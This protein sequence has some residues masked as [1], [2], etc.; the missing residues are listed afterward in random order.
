MI[1]VLDVLCEEFFLDRRFYTPY[2]LGVGA[3]CEDWWNDASKTAIMAKYGW[4]SQSSC[5]RYYT[6]DGS[7]TALSYPV[8]LFATF[9]ISNVT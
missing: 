7:S 2:C 8:S 5:D 9:L 4:Q 3:A 6:I 1:R